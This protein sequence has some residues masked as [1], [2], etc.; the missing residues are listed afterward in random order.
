MRSILA[1]ALLCAATMKASAQYPNGYFV[2][3]NNATRRNELP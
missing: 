3:G 1:L 2:D